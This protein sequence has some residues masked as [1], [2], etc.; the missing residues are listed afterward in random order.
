MK[1]FFAGLMAALFLNFATAQTGITNE[2]IWTSPEFSSEMVSGLNSMNDGLHYTSLEEENKATSIVKYSYETGQKVSVVATAKEIFGNDT[3]QIEGYEFSADEKQIL[4]ET[5]T[6]PI[7]RYSYYA[8]YFIYNLETKKTVPLADFRKGKQRLATFSPNGQYVAFVRDNN[9]FIFN[10]ANK[11]ETQVSTDGKMNEIINGATDWVYEE[12]FA[13]VRGFDWSPNSDKLAYLSFHEKEV[14]EYGMDMYGGLYPDRVTFKYPKAGEKNSVVKV[15]I[16]E[17]KGAMNNMVD[18]GTNPDQ[19]IPRLKWTQ[20]NNQLCVMRMNR[21]QNNLEF[22]L[23]D[24]SKQEPFMKST[25]IIFSETASTYIDVSDALSFMKDGSGFLWTS[26][27]NEFNHIYHFDMKGNMIADLTPGNF[28]VVDFYGVDEAGTTIYYSTSQVSATEKHVY[29][30][31]YKKK[32]A[33]PMQLTTAEGMNDANFSKNFKFFILNHSDAN[34]PLDVTLCNNSGKL[35]RV[36]KDNAELKSRLGKYSFT[37]KEFFTMKNR[38]GVELNAWM[39]K[40]K[41]F[42]PSKKYPVL[43]AIYG[44]PGHNTVMNQW[45]GRGYVWHQMLCQEGYIVVSVDPR[46]TQYRGRQFKHATYKNLGAL[47]TNDF[48]DCAKWLQQQTYVDAKRVGIQGWSFGGYM[49]SLC[50]TKGADV[51]ATGIAVA[52]VT[53]W[54]YYDSIYTER[55]LRTPADNKNG[56]EDNSPINFVKQLKGKFLLVHGSADDNVHFQNTMDMVTALVNANKQFD[57]FVY[58]NKNHSIG[59]G[60]TRLHLYTKMTNFLKENL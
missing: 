36:L 18:V 46:G 58:P 27:R 21:L 33:T 31:N 16:Y 29:S 6:E 56:Y 14:P 45:E 10:S 60:T 39:M 15:F 40:P 38:D 2:L 12:E 20:N 11:Q 32:K 54:K 43:V 25:S 28:D 30:Y 8:N 1:S 4:I 19:Y 22:L 37:K 41:N 17:L 48:I 50:M 42:D 3:K 57:L 52:P 26:E 13:I 49:T 55:F 53:N 59:G 7:Y 47:E 44:G 35:I 34:N 24:L 51:Y 9:I 23:T 5:E